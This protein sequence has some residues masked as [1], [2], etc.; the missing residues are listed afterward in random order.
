MPPPFVSLV[1]A[2]TDAAANELIVQY[3]YVDGIPGEK[4]EN[5]NLKEN[6]FIGNYISLKFM[7]LS[8]YSFQ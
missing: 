3:L 8:D 5:A 2:A 1:R 7:L 4:K 6:F